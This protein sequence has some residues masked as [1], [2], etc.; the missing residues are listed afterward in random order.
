MNDRKRQI[1]AEVARKSW[2][3]CILEMRCRPSAECVWA[4]VG[5]DGDGRGDETGVPRGGGREWGKRAVRR[6]RMMENV[7]I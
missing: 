3:T 4:M 6:G 1:S 2:E 5:G 7:G